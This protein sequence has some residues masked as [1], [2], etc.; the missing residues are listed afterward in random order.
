M[1]RSIREFEASDI[2]LMIHYF[3]NADHE[4]LRGMGVEPSKLPNSDKWRQI[5]LEDFERPV[6]HSRLYYLI[7]EIDD[8]P[9]G[10]SNLNKIIY[11]QEAFMHL[12]LWQPEKRRSGNGTYFINESIYCYFTKFHLQNLFC[13]PYALNPAPNKTL[14]KA[15][16]ELVK[17]YETTPGLINFNQTVNRWILTKEKWLQKSQQLAKG[18]G[19]RE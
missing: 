4:F 19:S 14:P 18:T 7:W 13:E 3:L 2:D 1:K 17:T 15:G 9:V 12:H 16:F 10:H 6:E 8:T 5:L 11:A